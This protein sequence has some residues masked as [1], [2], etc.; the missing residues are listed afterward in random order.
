MWHLNYTKAPAPGGETP[1]LG[2]PGRM[3]LKGTPLGQKEKV[4]EECKGHPT[5]PDHPQI[6]HCRAEVTDISV[7]VLECVCVGVRLCPSPASLSIL[8]RN[9]QEETLS[10]SWPLHTLFMHRGAPSP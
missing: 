5:G 7:Q 6:P 3:R 8:L 2:R 9:N 1:L 4:R 10:V